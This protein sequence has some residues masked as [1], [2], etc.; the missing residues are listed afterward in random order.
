MY[1]VNRKPNAALKSESPQ[2]KDP[3]L[4]ARSL[5]SVF[6][7]VSIVQLIASSFAPSLGA[8]RDE[9]M[10]LDSAQANATSNSI[11]KDLPP[12][13][14]KVLKGQVDYC[15]PS[16]TPLK[17]KLATVPT[18]AVRMMDRDMDGNL[19][20]AKAGQEITAKV[21]E[22]L[23]IDE[24]KVIPEGTIFHG[25]VSEIVPPK[26][27]HRPGSLKLT[28]DSLRTPDGRT[29]AFRAQAD[30]LKK[31]TVK[32]KAKGF[33]RIMAYA[34]GGGIVGALVA[35]QVFGLHYTIAMHGYNIAGGAA[36]GALLASGYAIM[37]K[38]DRAV[39]EP[40]DDL[41]LQIDSD[42]LMPA[43]EEPK[44]KAPLAVIPG[45]SMKIKKGKLIKD[46]LDGYILIV[47]AT[48][49][50]EGNGRLSSIDLFLED[51]NG[52]RQPITT[53]PGDKGDDSQLLF[54]IDP[55]SSTDIHLAFQ[56]EYPKLKRELVW[57]EHDSRKIAYRAALP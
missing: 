6:L 49:N 48:V 28:F 8:V 21:S 55:H 45:F 33:G 27:L 42:L 38:G 23:Y 5:A 32:T 56:V 39:L 20:P 10:E 43:A 24:N 17:L 53:E 7:T 15:V 12:P 30:N 26:R 37:Q 18:H 29:F 35:Y 46:G 41:H 50:N 36:A 19:L 4:K 13:S 34:G 52:N 25:K 51:S 47:D 22:D 11:N 2:P 1:T 16:G 57:L 14:D 3:P 40:G 9:E 54:T 31:S 44:P